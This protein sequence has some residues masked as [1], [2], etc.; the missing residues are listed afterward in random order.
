MSYCF[1]SAQG[2]FLCQ[3]P[4]GKTE[5]IEHFYNAA[6]FSDSKIMQ[7]GNSI[8]AAQQTECV[9]NRNTAACQNALK[10]AF[11]NLGCNAKSLARCDVSA[12]NSARGAST[13]SCDAS[14]YKAEDRSAFYN[15]LLDSFQS[16]V[17]NTNASLFQDAT[18][19]DRKT[20][21]AYETAWTKIANKNSAQIL[22]SYK[23]A[24][25]NTTFEKCTNPL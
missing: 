15:S 6:N 7:F 19:K 3:T 22:S 23:N 1:Y 9:S 18:L 10:N 2:E 8:I 13:T 4:Q 11:N 12:T 20:I 24:V 5:N 25:N 17:V 21:P 14:K 16:K